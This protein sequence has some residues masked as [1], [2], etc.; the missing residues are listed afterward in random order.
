MSNANAKMAPVQWAFRRKTYLATESLLRILH[1]AVDT[2]GADV[3]S[4]IVYMAIT[5]AS[6]GGAMRNPDL[7]ANPP[8]AGPMPESM[9]RPVSRRAIAASTGLPRETVRRKVAQFLDRGL[10]V[11]ERSGVRIRSKLLEDPMHREFAMT[12]LREFARTAE[13]MERVGPKPQG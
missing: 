11:S 3:E 10:L 5:C 2:Y 9:Y 13:E 8:P 4:T 7:C 12:L 1:K 6:V